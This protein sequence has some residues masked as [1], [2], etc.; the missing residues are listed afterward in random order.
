MERS[1]EKF[2]KEKKITRRAFLKGILIILAGLV[3]SDFERSN[4]IK[5]M[6]YLFK[7]FLDFKIKELEGERLKFEEIGVNSPFIYLR[8]EKDWEKYVE[9]LEILKNKLEIQKF[10]IRIFISDEF[11]EGLGQYKQE[12]LEK[13]FKFYNFL[14]N[15]GVNFVLEIDLIDCYP[16][17]NSLKFNPVYG[18]AIPTSP[19]NP[20]QNIE[21]Y[22]QFFVNQEIKKYV[23]NRMKNILEFLKEKFGNEELI[24]S[25]ANEPEPPSKN[26]EEKRIILTQ[27]YFEIWGEIKDMIPSNWKVVAGVKN[28][29]LL[30]D[31]FYQI[32][33]ITPTLHLYPF[34]FSPEEIEDIFKK[35]PNVYLQELG[36]PYQIFGINLIFNLD[37]VIL[38]ALLKRYENLPI[39]L[40]KLDFY[41]DGYRIPFLT[42]SG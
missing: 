24:I 12:V 32:S 19:Y 34:D 17:G 26:Y 5:W 18:S 38:K 7:S 13:I 6:T 20:Q 27:W 11:E 25:I 30:T 9:Q 39:S 35:Y 22:S 14:K 42:N 33:G 21:G 28:P 3:F 41:E 10:R 37:S 4:F 16:I 36:F 31:E 1:F 40:W 2:L 8:D 29:F 23:I 15:K